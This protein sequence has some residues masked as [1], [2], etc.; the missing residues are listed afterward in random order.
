VVYRAFEGAGPSPLKQWDVITRIADAPIDDEGM[1]QVGDNLRLAFQYLIQKVAHDG[2]VPLTIVRAG[3]SQSIRLPVSNHRPLLI[4]FLA[5]AYP[6]YFIYGPLVFSRASIESL[7]LLRSRGSMPAAA[8]GNPLV[9]RLGDPPDA[10]HDELVVIPS[11]LFPHALSKGYSNPAGEIVTAVNGTPV[12][13]LA[14][15][16]GLLRDLKDEFVSIDFDNKSGEALVFPREQTVAATEEILTDNGVRAQ[17]S[18]DMMK[19]WQG[20]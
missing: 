20:K 9:A 7:Q 6:P 1:I 11:P 14:Q 2:A 17:G 8:L 15:L 19:I 12:K 16:V 3:K 18:A 5:G 4:D 13:S 10:A